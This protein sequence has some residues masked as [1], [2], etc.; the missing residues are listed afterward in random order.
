MKKKILT[1]IL[2]GSLMLTGCDKFDR[3]MDIIMENETEAAEPETPETDVPETDVPETDVP[4]TP[5]Q[6]APVPPEPS[7]P[8][9]VQSPD[10]QDFA[11]DD[12]PMTE[13]TPD[14]E[15]VSENLAFS[16]HWE[17]LF[18]DAD[19]ND[20]MLYLVMTE[21]GRASYSYGYGNS[22]P[23]EFFG[24][25][26]G[27]ADIYLGLNFMGGVMD[28]ELGYVPDPYEFE[29]VYSYEWNEYGASFTAHLKESS[30][31]LYGTENSDLTFTCTAP[32][33]E[34]FDPYA[35]VKPTEMDPFLCIG[36]WY[37]TYD[38]P[39]GYELVMELKLDPNGKASYLYRYGGGAGE[40]YESFDGTWSADAAGNFSLDMHGGW[41][42]ADE[43]ETYDFDAKFRWDLYGN[44]LSLTHEEGNPLM[45]GCENWGFEFLPFDYTQHDGEWVVYDAMRQYSL[46]LFP[47]GEVMYTVREGDAVV[48]SYE[49]WWSITD[50]AELELSMRLFDGEG[51]EYISCL[52]DYEWVEFLSQLKLKL[53]D[54]GYALTNTMAVSGEDVFVWIDPDA[55]G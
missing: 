36:S 31:L 19:G 32:V 44:H 5:E 23:A 40:V 29:S 8:E 41:V 22:E 25:T 35:G 20:V 11:P 24:G 17:C 33:M 34:T 15:P 21:D 27:I 12:P 16:G 30:A 45:G 2:L 53:R 51:E 55:V 9:E 37:S 50:F 43:G 4:Q 10:N 39:D 26:W 42:N 7:V 6:P 54:G 48:C 46:N 1:L 14:E 47:N 49:G 13:G 28:P 38:H 18:T 52:Y 3:I